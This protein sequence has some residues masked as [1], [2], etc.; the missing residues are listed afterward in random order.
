ML[1][2]ADTP[3]MWILG[4]VPL[5]SILMKYFTCVSSFLP[6]CYNALARYLNIMYVNMISNTYLLNFQTF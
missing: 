3:V 5:V 4:S 6:S 1:Y 2:N